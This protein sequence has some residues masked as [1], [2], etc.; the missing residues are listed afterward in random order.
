[1]GGVHSNI[2]H[3]AKLGI[4]VFLLV[5]VPVLPL[6]LFVLLVCIDTTCKGSSSGQ[7]TTADLCCVGVSLHHRRQSNKPITSSPFLWS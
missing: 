5:V 1:M 2:V 7:E 3:R 4:R 6:V